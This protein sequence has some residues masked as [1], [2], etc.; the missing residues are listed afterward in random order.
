VPGSPAK[1]EIIRRITTEGP[2]VMPPTSSHK[3]LTPQQIATL[4]R[5]V[6][7]GADY[8]PHWSYI[9]PKR[10]ALPKVKNAAWARNPIDRF[11]LARL[12][13][14]GL[15]PAPKPISARSFDASAWT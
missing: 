14:A 11:V 3:K 2:L 5:W 4:K 12:E 10:A 9:A 13:Q 8:E 15:T 6:A 7:E 1:S